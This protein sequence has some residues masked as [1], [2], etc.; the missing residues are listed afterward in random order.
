MSHNE[1]CLY[2]E[3]VLLLLRNGVKMSDACEA[4]VFAILESRK[5]GK[6]DGN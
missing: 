4:G 5:A 1:F 2:Q 3:V 6:D